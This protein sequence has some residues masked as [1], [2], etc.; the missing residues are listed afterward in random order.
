MRREWLL[1]AAALLL[2]AGARAFWTAPD[3]AAELA[4]RLIGSGQRHRLDGQ[5]SFRHGQAALLFFEQRGFARPF[6]GAVLIENGFIEDVIM[7]DAREGLDQR[8][9]DDPVLLARYRGL[10]ARLPLLVDG[11]AGATVSTRALQSAVHGR[12]R[13]WQEGG[14]ALR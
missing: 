13:A 14:H 9:F 10:P 6:R 3:P 2:A 1:T 5:P 7:L 12:L 8:L 11:V 4:Q